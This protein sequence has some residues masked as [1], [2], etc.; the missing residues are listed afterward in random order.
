MK[1]K[2][3]CEFCGIENEYV[4]FEGLTECFIC[5]KCL[6]EYKEKNGD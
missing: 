1:E 4:R 6:F 5:D 3:I 2:H